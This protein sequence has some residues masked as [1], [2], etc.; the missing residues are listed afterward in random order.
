[1]RAT[2]FLFLQHC[3][4]QCAVWRLCCAVLCCVRSFLPL[5][6]SCFFGRWRSVPSSFLASSRRC[7]PSSPRHFH[8]RHCVRAVSAEPICDVVGGVAPLVVSCASATV[9]ALAPP[10]PASVLHR[11]YAG[12]EPH[13]AWSATFDATTTL[14]GN[15]TPQ[16]LLALSSSAVVAGSRSAQH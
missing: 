2:R 11:V 10:E 15:S 6:P 7:A 13:L 5:L 16:Y 8:G 9:G 12:K 4:G 1:M 14:A 3:A